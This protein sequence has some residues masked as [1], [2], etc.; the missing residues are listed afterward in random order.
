VTK[1]NDGGMVKSELIGKQSTCKLSEDEE[2]QLLVN[3][4]SIAWQKTSRRGAS[5]CCSALYKPSSEL[6][7]RS[8]GEPAVNGVLVLCYYSQ[9]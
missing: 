9:G 5:I 2:P 4:T 7:S 6:A 3:A 8:I 1:S